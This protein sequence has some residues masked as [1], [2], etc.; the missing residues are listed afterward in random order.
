MLF[1]KALRAAGFRLIL[2]FASRSQVVQRVEVEPAWLPPAWARLV[3]LVELFRASERAEL[4]RG[5]LRAMLRPEVPLESVLWPAA[6][7]I[8]MAARTRAM[9]NRRIHRDCRCLQPLPPRIEGLLREPLLCA[10]LLN[11]YAALTLRRDPGAP[12]LAC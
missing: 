8:A 7:L 4:V 10:I 3:R 1:W 12:I 9:T 2:P 5:S 11:R 6:G